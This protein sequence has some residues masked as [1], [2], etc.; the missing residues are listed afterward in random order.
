MATVLDLI[1][2][3][4]EPKYLSENQKKDSTALPPDGQITRLQPGWSQRHCLV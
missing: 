3:K 1:W 2:G 4:W